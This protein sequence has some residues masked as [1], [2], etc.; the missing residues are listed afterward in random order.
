MKILKTS[1]FILSIIS[2]ISITET[3]KAIEYVYEQHIGKI[4]VRNVNVEF[5]N[6]GVNLSV[7]IHTPSCPNQNHIDGYVQVVY[8]NNG[9]VAPRTWY[10]SG[11][12]EEDID[13]KFSDF[14]PYPQNPGGRVRVRTSSRCVFHGT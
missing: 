10:F 1:A 3:A 11:S 5:A 7:N 6:D 12:D 4:Y 13:R 8:T 2:L 14:I 9:G